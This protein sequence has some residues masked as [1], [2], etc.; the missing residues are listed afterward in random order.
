MVAAG[1]APAAI[2]APS[3]AAE[4]LEWRS[5]MHRYVSVDGRIIDNGNGGVSHSEGQ[6]IGLISAAC[7]GDRAD[8]DLILGWTRRHLSR[9]YDALHSWCFNPNNSNPVSDENNAT[10]GDLLI[11]HALFLAA[12]RWQDAT[13]HGR[14][15][16]IARA[17]R[18]ALLRPTAAGIVL[19]PALDGFNDAT[20]LTFNP[21]YYVFPALRRFAQELPDPAWTAAWNDGMALLIRARFGPSRLSP[22]WGHLAHGGSAVSM[23][24]NRPR[25]CSYDAIRLPLYLCWAARADHPVVGA[26]ASYWAIHGGNRAP[27]WSDL[28]TDDVAPYSLTPGMEAIRQLVNFRLGL[29]TRCDLPTIAST[30]DYYAAALIMLV[31]VALALPSNTTA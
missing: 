18:D 7:F 6:G 13:Y 3:A 31:H 23:A 14:G 11:G 27:A 9:S 4:V 10:D 5:F 12:E 20:G 22:D 19:L 24:M 17:V 25:R 28:E 26:F 15:V 29:T 16:A 21:S 8:F 1:I 2:A 30:S